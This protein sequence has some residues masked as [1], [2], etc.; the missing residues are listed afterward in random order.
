MSTQ[1]KVS[2]VVNAPVENVWKELRDFTFPAR[3]ISTVESA[4]VRPPPL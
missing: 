1:V 3:L 4:E 2:A